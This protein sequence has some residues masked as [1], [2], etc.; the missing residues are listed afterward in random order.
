L[1]NNY[2]FELS[3]LPRNCTNEEII[4]EVKR[5]G[6]LIKKDVLSQDDFNKY[7]KVS[8][9]TARKRFGSWKKVLIA[10]GLSHRYADRPEFKKA[11]S[12]KFTD[13][14]II[15]ELQRIAKLIGKES[16]SMEDFMKNSSI[17]IHPESVR[18]RFGSWAGLMEKAELK[19]SPKYHRRYSNEE[20]FENLLNVWTYLGRQPLYRE[21]DEYPSTISSGAY[22]GRF[23]SWRKALEA[24]VTRMNEDELENNGEANVEKTIPQTVNILEPKKEPKKQ[25]TIP[26]AEDRRGINLSLRYKILVRDN[27]RCVRCGRSPATTPSVELHIDHKNPFSNQGKTV[28]ENLETKCKECNLGKSHRHIE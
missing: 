5:V 6:S 15:I 28:L 10:A 2:K 13:E 19:L 1:K 16:I 9:S 20:Y 26:R 17:E 4:I 8:S 25:K 21:I 14:E 3:R 12:R 18:R 7:A 11:R 27:F 22:E 23:G 24:F